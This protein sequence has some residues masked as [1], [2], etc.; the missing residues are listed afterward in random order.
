MALD[1]INKDPNAPKDPVQTEYKFALD[2]N[3]V[4]D[5]VMDHSTK[6]A[7]DLGKVRANAKMVFFFFL[8][9]C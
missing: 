8:E 5:P 9:S 7:A 2:G 3:P 4:A 1:D 6:P